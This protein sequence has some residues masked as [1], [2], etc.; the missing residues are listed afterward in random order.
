MKSDSLD[1]P[2]N[3][4]MLSDINRFYLIQPDFLCK[5]ILSDTNRFYWMQTDFIRHSSVQTNYI[6]NMTILS[7]FSY[8]VTK[9]TT[10]TT[11]I[12]L[13]LRCFAT[14]GQKELP[15]VFCRYL[16]H[17][18]IHKNFSSFQSF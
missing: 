7:Y 3:K 18:H 10:A 4:P 15:F 5:P 11:T 16:S 6:G 9:V 13:G 12:F 2:L 14:R 8:S 1:L 17:S